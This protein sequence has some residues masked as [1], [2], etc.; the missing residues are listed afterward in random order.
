MRLEALLDEHREA[1]R[2]VAAAHGASNVRVFGSVARGQESS[3]SDLDLIIDV[4]KPWTLFDQS[5]LKLD[6]Q[7]LLG[8]T[9]DIV[10]A[11]YLEE[12]FREEILHEAQ[13]V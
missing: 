8:C 12:T 11:E 2:R 13:P 10:V 5:G 3:D 4:N 9:V 7:D 1:I 6:L